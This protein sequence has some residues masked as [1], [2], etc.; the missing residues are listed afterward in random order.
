MSILSAIFGCSGEWSK[1]IAEWT[2]SKKIA[3]KE[4][5][6]SH[7]SGLAVDEKF[8]YLTVGGTVAD[9]NE[10]LSGLRKIALDSGAVTI[11]DD[12]K[13]MPQA[14]NG[15]IALDDKFVYWNAGGKIWRISKDGGAPQIVAAEN[16]GIG[17]DLTL[18]DKKV[19]WT[20]H[21]YYSAN[22]PTLPSPIYAVQKTGGKAEIFA[23]QQQNP[24]G[25]AAD[26]KFVYWQTV[27][28]IWKQAKTGGKIE[29]V[30]Q[31]GDDENV[32]QLSQDG[33][34]LYFGFRGSGGSRWALRKISKQG[35]EPLTLV[36][37][38]SLQPIAVDEANIYYFDNNG[39]APNTAKNTL[40]KVSKNGGANTALDAGFAGGSVAQS[41]TMI[42]FAGLDELYSFV[43]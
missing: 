38:Y 39:T 33:E 17:V 41:K 20:D 24:G 4:Q 2:N 22:S 23:D 29:V 1:P 27:K 16:V 14:E 30:F 3:G 35:G 37:N 11:L 6:L 42:Y 7:I 8:A 19:Y 28:G 26:D 34:N 9:Q 31:V 13:N 5:K 43:K 21:K 36:E 32:G 15:G 10:G 25:L 18:D 12:G 40:R